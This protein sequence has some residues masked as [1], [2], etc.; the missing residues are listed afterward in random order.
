MDETPKQR[1]ARRRA[2]WTG[3]VR[4]DGTEGREATPATF[5]EIVA[6][7]VRSWLLS[8]RELPTYDRSSMPGRVI[9]PW[10]D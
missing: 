4:R 2:T 3:E 5:E 1:A 6:L 10:K 8:G 7:S 9:R